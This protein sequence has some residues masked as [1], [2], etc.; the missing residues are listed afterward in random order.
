MTSIKANYA[1]LVTLVDTWFGQLININTIDRLGLKENTLVVFL[2]DH[3][4]NFGE[5][6]D[7]ITRQLYVS[8]YNE[9]PD[10]DTASASKRSRIS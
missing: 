9:H 10:A 5:N 2:S 4:T 6:A 7:R 8:W 3:G 1:G